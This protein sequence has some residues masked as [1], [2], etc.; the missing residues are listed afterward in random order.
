MRKILEEDIEGKK[1][2]VR[3]DLNLPIKNGEPMESLRME[4]Y[5]ESVSYMAER[6]ARIVLMAHQGRPGD[7]DFTSL[8]KH[9]EIMEEELG[10]EVRFIPSFFGGELEDVLDSMED[11]DIALI[12][13]IRM[14][15]EELMNESVE[16][17]SKDFFVRRMSEEFDIY[18]NDAFSVAHRPHGSMM[19]FM[20][21][22]PAFAG[23]LMTD[24]I[25]SCKKARDELDS[26]VLVLGGAKPSDLVKM[27]DRMKER[28]DK[29][30]LG[31]IPGELALRLRGIKLDKKYSW[32]QRK[33]LDEGEEEFDRFL[34]E[35]PDLFELPVDLVTEEGVKRV[36]E[37]DGDEMV[38][39]IGPETVERY[40]RI[41]ADSKSLILKGPMGAFEE[42]YIDGTR[43]VIE[44][45]SDCDGYT[46]LGGGHTS[47]LLGD[48]DI[49]LE[50]FSHVSIAGG[51]FVRF[52][53]GE[54]LPVIEALEKY[55]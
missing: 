32:I 20:N 27:I 22:L 12:E 5:M 1:V 29:V 49:P 8:K 28:A 2:L 6:G 53:S 16:K 10:R 36:E 52:M 7:K 14:L 40:S 46:L 9:A 39:D 51:A 4:K 35:H 24:E 18:V 42:G 34:E 47:T 11:G 48:L 31:G 50:N 37:L 3:T 30:L 38:W 54:K 43:G 55:S 17:H 15:S 21:H 13:N 25:E 44:A 26:P 23:P 33:G 45:V 19:G 41:I